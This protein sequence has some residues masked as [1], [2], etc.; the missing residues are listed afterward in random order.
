MNSNSDKYYE[1]NKMDQ[2]LEID[3]VETI[4]NRVGQEK[5]L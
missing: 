3:G 2:W 4:L 1:E 5:S